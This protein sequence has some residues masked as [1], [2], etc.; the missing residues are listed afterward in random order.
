MGGWAHTC[1][2]LTSLVGGLD[3]GTGPTHLSR[4]KVDLDLIT[5]L[6]KYLP[7]KEKQPENFPSQMTLLFIVC[8]C[9]T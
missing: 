3:Y 7:T 2:Y 8:L 6:Y 5:S 1:I 4:L 9:C